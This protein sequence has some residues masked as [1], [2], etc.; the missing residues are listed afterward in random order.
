MELGVDARVPRCIFRATLCF[1]LHNAE[2]V[3]S[4]SVN[5]VASLRTTRSVIWLGYF[6]ACAPALPSLILKTLCIEFAG[7]PF[8][9]KLW[10]GDGV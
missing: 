7:F 10:G 1:S 3:R 4:L 9:K 2:S 5:V 8:E 6:E